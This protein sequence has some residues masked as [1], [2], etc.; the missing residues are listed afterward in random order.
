MSGATFLVHELVAEIGTKAIA[1]VAIRD[2]LCSLDAARMPMWRYFCNRLDDAIAA[3]AVTLKVLN[4][5]LAKYHFVSRSAVL[6][7]R[8]FGLLVDPSNGC[9]LACPGCVHSSH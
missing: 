2:L 5:I 9:N 3:K 4:L 7:S 6:V 8:P 1:R